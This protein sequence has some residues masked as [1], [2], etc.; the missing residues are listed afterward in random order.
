[1]LNW[2]NAKMDLLVLGYYEKLDKKKFLRIL[3]EL[4]LLTLILVLL[5]KMGVFVSLFPKPEPLDSIFDMVY[6]VTIIPVI[7]ELT[8]RVFLVYFINLWLIN[9][10]NGNVSN[11]N[12]DNKDLPPDFVAH[13]KR[14]NAWLCV[15]IVAGI[16]CNFF[17]LRAIG[18]LSQNIT[19]V[20]YVVFLTAAILLFNWQKKLSGLI[21]FSFIIGSS[22]F[23][24]LLHTNHNMFAGFILFALFNSWLTIKYRSVA[25]PMVIHVWNNIN[26]IIFSLL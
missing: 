23:F 22:F 17:L 12:L 3:T 8:T 20:V 18:S 15:G 9:Y 10:F 6:V 1:M 24:A 13:A 5:K 2:L 7:E 26:Y 25:L 16:L 4:A 21:F 14:K 11:N 19:Y